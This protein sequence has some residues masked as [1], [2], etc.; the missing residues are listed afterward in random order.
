MAVEVESSMPPARMADSVSLS[1][2]MAV[3]SPGSI[4]EGTICCLAHIP[5]GVPSGWSSSQAVRS[6][7][8]P[9]SAN[10]PQAEAIPTLS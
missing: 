7:T 8:R 6:V 1:V 9:Y 10:P 3:A 4:S 2:M 5:T